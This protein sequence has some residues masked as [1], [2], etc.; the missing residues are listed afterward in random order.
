[1]FLI[2]QKMNDCIFCKI[3]KGEVNSEK[4]KETNNFFA[5][6]DIN[7]IANG[8]T[9]VI[10][11]RHFTTILDIPN[12]LAEEMIK[13]IKDISDELITNKKADGFNIISNNLKPAGQI[14]PHL[15]IHII[16]R[17]EGDK[18]KFLTK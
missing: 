5:I 16:P 11:K 1:M 18:I 9:L 6:H 14:V 3:A 2:L 8:H 15:H 4:I 13:L 7:P 12:T 10:P 17:K